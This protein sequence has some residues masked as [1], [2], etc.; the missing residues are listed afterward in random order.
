MKKVLVVLVIIVI[1]GY[2]ILQN[3]S[4]WLLKLMSMT[5]GSVGNIPI[6]TGSSGPVP[7]FKN[8]TYNGTSVNAFYGNIQ[9]QAVITGGKIASVQFLQY[10]NDRARSIAINTLAMPN[11]SQEAIQAQSANVT[12]VSGATDSSNAFM[13]SL[14]S[15]LTQAK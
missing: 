8:G 2:A 9:V 4:V 11:L 7:P 14:A 6:A 10:P 5:S 13:Q 3:G 15:A 12:I 1:F